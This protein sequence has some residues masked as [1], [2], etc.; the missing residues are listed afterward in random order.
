MKHFQSEVKLTIMPGG[1]AG[2]DLSNKL[3]QFLSVLSHLEYQCI[4]PSWEV[5]VFQYKDEK[6]SIAKLY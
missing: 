4:N 6:S 3:V 1:V 2:T 5:I